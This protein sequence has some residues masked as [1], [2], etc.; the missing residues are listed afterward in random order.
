MNIGVRRRKCGVWRHVGAYGYLTE[1]YEDIRM[2]TDDIYIYMYIYTY[3]KSWAHLIPGPHFIPGLRL[4]PGPIMY[5]WR[6]FLFS[7]E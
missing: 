6:I 5:K 2:R 7:S 3:I 1:A 4:V